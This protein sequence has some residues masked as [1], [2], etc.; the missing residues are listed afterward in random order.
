MLSCLQLPGGLAD[1]K[2]ELLINIFSVADII[3]H[4]ARAFQL[5]ERAVI[6]GAQAILVLEALQFFDVPSQIVLGA[7]KFPAN[8][9]AGVLGQRAEL[10]QGRRKEFDLIVHLPALRCVP[11]CRK[12]MTAQ[13]TGY[14]ADERIEAMMQQV[15]E[16]T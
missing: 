9:T 13:G 11:L 8:Q 6:A 1:V 12:S 15:I 3:Y 14:W 2:V 16:K 10:L 7:V 5:K 4:E